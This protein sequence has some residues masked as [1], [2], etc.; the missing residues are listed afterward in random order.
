[1]TS[2]HSIILIGM[3]GSGKSTIGKL[4][5]DRLHRQF[6]DTDTLI[7]QFTDMP[8]QVFLEKY[9]RS[10]FL[11]TESERV[12]HIQAK[13]SVIATGGSV[14]YRPASMQHLKTIGT[15]VFLN[16]PLEALRKRQL[17]YTNRGFIIDE[18]QSFEALFEERFALY[19]RYADIDMDCS[20]KSPET[21]CSE[22]I[23]VLFN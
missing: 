15:L 8:L 22:L 2:D 19:R 9:G 1:M 23:D 13:H 11:E 20:A 6:I 10:H 5:A 14:V 18:G 12:L 17:D 16:V 4:L 21:I 7:E 3:A